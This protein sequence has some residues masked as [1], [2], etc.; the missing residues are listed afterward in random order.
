MSK[1]KQ[2][3]TPRPKEKKKASGIFEDVTQRQKQKS[4]GCSMK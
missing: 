3:G 2:A 4:K 1:T